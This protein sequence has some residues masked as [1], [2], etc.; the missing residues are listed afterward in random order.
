MK[1]LFSVFVAILMLVSGLAAPS[2]A[3][4]IKIGLMCPLTGDW[5]SE[6]Q[7]MRNVVSLMVD[8]INADGGINGNKIELVVADD[9]GKP[10]GAALAAR[11]LVTSGVVA[12][13]GTYGSAVTEASQ[14]VYDEA[15]IVQIGTGSTSV[16]LTEKGLPRFFRTSP[17]DDDQGRVAAELLIKNN[18]RR[19]ALLHDNSSYAKGLADETRAFLKESGRDVIFFES[20]TPGDR[21]YS[22][23]LTKLKAA[24]PD[25]I[26]FTGYY[27]E[28][29]LLLRQKKSM[30]FDAP[31]MGGDATNNQD[32]VK[33][34]GKAAATGYSF[35]S[36]PV[37]QDLDSPSAKAFLAAYLDKN[38]AYP[39]SIWAVLAGD[40]LQVIVEAIKQTGKAD[41]ASIADYLHNGLKDF[42]GLT[43]PIMFDKK[44]DRVGDI[45]RV[46]VVDENGNFTLK[47]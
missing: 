37:P 9:E 1:R 2:F 6:G 31:M 46:Y 22:T 20:L 19:I 8:T 45:Y 32:L 11:K 28:A 3:A 15:G 25:G 21:D 18:Y 35:I 12:V 7:D 14:R 47:K 30:G 23:I 34:A 36:P 16:R 24:N 26:F 5:A 29:G 27:Q 38:G 13:I 41:S 40:A 39:S 10:G 17:R 43:G 4:T 33:I 44:G 42:T